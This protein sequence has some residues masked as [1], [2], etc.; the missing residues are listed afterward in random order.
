MNVCQALIKL[1]KKVPDDVQVIGFD[2][3]RLKEDAPYLVSTIVQSVQ[4]MAEQA[5]SLLIQAIND[6]EVDK[7]TILPVHFGSGKTT[8]EI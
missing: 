7:R 3:Q 8:K 6:E 5:A 4:Q 1:G 2:G